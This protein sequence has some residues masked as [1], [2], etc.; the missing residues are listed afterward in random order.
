MRRILP[1]FHILPVQALDS[2]QVRPRAR[3]VLR[4][5]GLQD[6]PSPAN[7]PAGQAGDVTGTLDLFEPPA[8][9]RAIPACVAA[10]QADPK[11]SLNKIAARTGYNRMRV[12]QALACAKQMAAVGLS[13]PYRE[14]TTCPASAS[15]WR[16][17]GAHESADSGSRDPLCPGRGRRAA[18]SAQAAPLLFSPGPTEDGVTANHKHGPVSDGTRHCSNFLVTS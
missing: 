8:Y 7:D 13:G 17:R 12:R 14:L 6:R 4:L 16:R 3:F 5:S 1:D 15:R 11:S 10:Q 18:L 2:S 9:I